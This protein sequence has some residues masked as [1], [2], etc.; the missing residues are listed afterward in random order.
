MT[1]IFKGVMQ[2]IGCEHSP[3]LLHE[4]CLWL[5]GFGGGSTVWA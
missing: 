1:A 2:M 5:A 3:E 4:Q